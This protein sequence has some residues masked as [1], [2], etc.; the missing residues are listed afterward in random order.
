[1]SRTLTVTFLRPLLLGEEVRIES[2]AVHAGKRMASLR[3][4]MR[5]VSDGEVCLVCVHD[6][7]DPWVGK[8]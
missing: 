4:V 8:L 6:K 1:M 3:G 5:R 7:V 2:E